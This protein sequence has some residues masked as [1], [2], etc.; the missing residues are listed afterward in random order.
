[1][2]GEARTSIELAPDSSGD[3]LVVL[4]LED[5]ETD[6]RR[7]IKFARRAGLRAEFHEAQDLNGLAARLE[8][9]RFD[10][11]YVDYHL[12][13]A[14]GEEALNLIFACADQEGAMTIMVTSV[15]TPEIMAATIR[16]GCADYLVK[17]RID[18]GSLGR[19]LISSLERLILVFSLDPGERRRDMLRQL[20]GRL[21]AAMAPPLRLMTCAMLRRTLKLCSDPQTP[22]TGARAV[23]EGLCLELVAVLER[24]S[25]APLWNEEGAA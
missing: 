1:M 13:L 12:G 20:V 11:I 14:T 9:R 19:S 2:S 24:A 23:L 7:L 8:A 15:E 4:V 16:A 6:R 5:D 22:A 21:D 18:P 10:L 25:A 17:D 3:A